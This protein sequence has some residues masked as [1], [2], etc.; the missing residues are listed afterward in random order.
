MIRHF[1]QS[2]D[3]T[4]DPVSLA[5][6]TA[7]R[8]YHDEEQIPYKLLTTNDMRPIVILKTLPFSNLW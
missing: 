8:H 3:G 5:E 4:A 6:F 2:I 1:L 7:A